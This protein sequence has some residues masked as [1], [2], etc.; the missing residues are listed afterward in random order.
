VVQPVFPSVLETEPASTRSG[1]AQLPH[2][3]QSKVATSATRAFALSAEE[4]QLCVLSRGCRQLR[5]RPR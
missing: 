2:T 4:A 3:Y 5:S 1:Y